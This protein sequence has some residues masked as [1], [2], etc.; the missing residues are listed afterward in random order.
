MQARSQSAIWIKEPSADV[1]VVIVSS[2]ELPKYMID[3]LHLAIDDWDQVAYLAVNQSRQLMLD[4]L[5]VESGSPPSS[6]ADASDA[7]QLLCRVA[8]GSFLLEVEAGTSPGLA[9][10]G[11]VCGHPLRVIDLGAVASSVEQMD[12]QVEQVLAAIRRLAKSLL[13][14]RGVI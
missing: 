7:R 9:W 13:Q 3:Q 11:S 14:E 4:W 2:V 12:Q 10:L 8:K 5:R 6:L 1:G